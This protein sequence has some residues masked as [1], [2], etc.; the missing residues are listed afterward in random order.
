M[1]SNDVVH[2]LRDSPCTKTRSATAFSCGVYKVFERNG[3][4]NQV[5]LYVFEAMFVDIC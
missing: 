3:P 4:F 2:K 5:R 1:A